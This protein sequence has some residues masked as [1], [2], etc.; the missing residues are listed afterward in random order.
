MLYISFRVIMYQICFPDNS[1]ILFPECPIFG[2]FSY[3]FIPHLSIE[4]YDLGP[5]TPHTSTFIFSFPSL[6][7][8]FFFS[9]FSLS[10]LVSDTLTQANEE[11]V[12]LRKKGDGDKSSTRKTTTFALDDETK[13][14]KY[15]P[16]QN[17][18]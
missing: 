14:L 7:F 5:L 4:D 12:R 10:S 3:Y 11:L 15:V 1:A 17:C 18:T 8:H 16:F 9:L 6:H 13:N 2:A